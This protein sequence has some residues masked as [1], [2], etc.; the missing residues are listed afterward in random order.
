MLR[1]TRE[2]R[3]LSISF[4]GNKH[5]VQNAN[6]AVASEDCMVTPLLVQIFGRSDIGEIE[7]VATN[8]D[9]DTLRKEVSVGNLDQWLFDRVFRQE[10]QPA[11]YWVTEDKIKEI[12]TVSRRYRETV[13]G[14]VGKLT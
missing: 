2:N 14:E 13:R 6:V 7:H 3:G 12:L 9:M 1:E 8:W 10:E 4:N 5:A 11:V